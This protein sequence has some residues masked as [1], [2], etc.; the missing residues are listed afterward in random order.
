MTVKEVSQLIHLE[1]GRFHAS[2]A[3][4]V[5]HGLFKE[6]IN[7]NKIQRLRAWERHHQ[8]ETSPWDEKIEHISTEM[9]YADHLI[10]EAKKEGFHLEINCNVE[11]KLVPPTVSSKQFETLEN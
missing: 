4:D 9:E 7:F 3:H 8:C 6:R 10:A 11:I 2:E 5:L 1:N